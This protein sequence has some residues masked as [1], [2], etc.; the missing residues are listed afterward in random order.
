MI[1]VIKIATMLIIARFVVASDQGNFL[2]R[3]SFISPLP[4]PKINEYMDEIRIVNPKFSIVFSVVKR[5]KKNIEVARET[6]A[7]VITF[8]R[9]IQINIFKN[10]IKKLR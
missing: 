2:L 9:V 1:L 10:R 6:H 4:P 5:K 7:S 3:K 8:L